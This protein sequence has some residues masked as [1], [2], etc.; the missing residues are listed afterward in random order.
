MG[1]KLRYFFPRFSVMN[2]DIFLT[3]PSVVVRVVARVLADSVFDVPRG[4]FSY[5]KYSRS[6][7]ARSD[8]K[9]F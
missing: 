2:C 4:M 1:K 8:S 9:V 5:P 6:F 7:F 3:F